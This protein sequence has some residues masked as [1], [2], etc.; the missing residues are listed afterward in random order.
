VV[1][2]VRV[3]RLER[4]IVALCTLVRGRQIRECGG[5]AHG[6]RFEDRPSNHWDHLSFSGCGAHLRDPLVELPGDMRHD[7]QLPL[8]EH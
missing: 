2:D 4:V 3:E 7:A 5:I 1:A 6:S 8:N